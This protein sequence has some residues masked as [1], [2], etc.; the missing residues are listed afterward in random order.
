VSLAADY[1]GA[2]LVFVVGCPRSGTTWVQRLL[3][4]HPCVRTGQESDVFDEYIGPLLRT[5]ER[6]LHHDTSGRGGVGLACYFTDTEFRR[7]LKG[8]LLQ[9]LE[10]MVGALKPGELFVEKTPSHVLFAREIHALL[11]QARFVHVVRDA[12]DTVASLLDASRGW[13]RAWAPRRAR[14]AAA[15]WVQ[16]MQAGAEARQQLPP[17]QWFD[18]RYE[19]LHQ[20]GPTRLRDLANW[21]ALAWTDAEI[22]RALQDNR[23]ELAQAGKATPIPLGGEFARSSGTV[24]KEPAGFVGQARAGAWRTRLNALDKL[25]VWQVARTTMADAGYAWTAP[26]SA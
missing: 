7:V 24:V 16:H 17:R 19:T 23:V 21:L 8:Y 22:A 4:S 1:G 10:P 20:D 18:V 11:P 6:E 26:W 3:A 13:G 12:R 2:S 14:H 9:L 5:W 25:A 15:T